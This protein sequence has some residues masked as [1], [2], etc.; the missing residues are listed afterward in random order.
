MDEPLKYFAM[1]AVMHYSALSYF[2][3]MQQHFLEVEITVAGFMIQFSQL[4]KL[5]NIL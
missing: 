1:E 5:Q 2:V 3:L 4:G